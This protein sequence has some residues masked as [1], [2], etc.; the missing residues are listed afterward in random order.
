M[1][2][3]KAA[4]CGADMN[5]ETRPDGIKRREMPENWKKARRVSSHLCQTMPRRSVISVT[6]ACDL[7][8]K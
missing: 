1:I 6:I 8:E 5:R 7:F 4:L 3:S 2:E